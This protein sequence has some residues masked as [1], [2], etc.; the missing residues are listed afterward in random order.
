[1]G[2]TETEISEREGFCA[3]LGCDVFDPVKAGIVAGISKLFGGALDAVVGEGCAA[4]VGFDRLK[5]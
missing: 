1:M 3:V 4:E 2:G 5:I